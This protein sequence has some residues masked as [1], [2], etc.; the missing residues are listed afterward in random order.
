MTRS[1]PP[2]SPST[3]APTRPSRS[4]WRSRARY[5]TCRRAGRCMGRGRGTMCLRARTGAGDSGCRRWTRG[6]RWR[7]TRR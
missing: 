2:N 4:T 7:I 6:T 3:T 1:P 5:S